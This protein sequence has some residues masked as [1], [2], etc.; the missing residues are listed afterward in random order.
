M[1]LDAYCNFYF[2]NKIYTIFWINHN[3][4]SVL[5]CYLCV[6]TYIELFLS[7]RQLFIPGIYA[8]FK[9]CYFNN[10]RATH[11][12]FQLVDRQQKTRQENVRIDDTMKKLD[13]VSNNTISTNSYIQ[14]IIIIASILS[15]LFMTCKHT[16]LCQNIFWVGFLIV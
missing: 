11:N 12:L 15:H 2:V 6:A 3:K 8:I 13:R 4:S 5:M 16:K 1:Y 9:L 10:F 14:S 7:D